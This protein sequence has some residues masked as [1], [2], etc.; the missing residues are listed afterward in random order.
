[1]IITTTISN[2]VTVLDI[3]K[4]FLKIILLSESTKLFLNC[5]AKPSQMEMLFN[6]FLIACFEG[7]R[8]LQVSFNIF[9]D[10][11]LSFFDK[12]AASIE[13]TLLPLLHLA[14]LMA[15]L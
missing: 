6:K 3:Q 1:M 5:S 4:L 13:F 15:S 11:F 14:S 9:H 12:A 8:W 2:T 7:V 10:D